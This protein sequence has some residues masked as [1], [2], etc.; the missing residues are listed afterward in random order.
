MPSRQSSSAWMYLSCPFCSSISVPSIQAISRIKAVQ[1]LELSDQTSPC[2]ARTAFT[3]SSSLIRRRLSA[4]ERRETWIWPPCP[5]SCSAG[6]NRRSPLPVQRR[7]D[8][9]AGLEEF[10]HKSLTHTERCQTM[11]A[12]TCDALL[13]SDTCLVWFCFQRY[14]LELI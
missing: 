14:R 3:T 12:A 2:A 9:V 6:A 11:R 5:L 8:D 10:I 1:I 13:K 4:A 7:R